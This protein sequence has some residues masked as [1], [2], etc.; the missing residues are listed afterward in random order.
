M[1]DLL[2][3]KEAKE[4]QNLDDAST[5]EVHRKIIQ[6]KTILKKFY[7]E[8]YER[9]T[10]PFGQ[11]IK[12]LKIIE[13]GAGCYNSKDHGHNIIATDLEYN[14]YIDWPCDAQ[15]MPFKDE[16]IDGFIVLDVLHHIPKPK[17]FFNEVNRTL[18]SGGKINIIEPYFSPWSSLFY[19]HLHHEPVYDIESWDIPINED[20]QAGRLT[21][22]N[23]IMPYHI[24]IRDRKIFEE[25]YPNLKIENITLFN[26][27]TYLVSGGLSF[28]S[29]LPGFMC[30]LVKLLEILLTPFSKLLSN[31]MCIEIT[32]R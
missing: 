15:N 10:A 14:K 3:L 1:L 11:A 17:Q 26:K 9:L 8:C 6:K 5:F 22:A 29:F 20:M 18:K 25:L 31:S 27:L 23:Q 24:F 7:Q 32:K 13:I 12:K 2:R 28:I 4:I 16:E 19:R 30:P 21:V